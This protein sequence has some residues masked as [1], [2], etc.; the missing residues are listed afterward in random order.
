M[1]QSSTS[2]IRDDPRV[3]SRLVPEASA[4]PQ[5]NSD[6]GKMI[7]VRQRLR[8]WPTSKALRREPLLGPLEKPAMRLRLFAVLATTCGRPAAILIIRD[9]LPAFSVSAES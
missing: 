7:L 2:W 8:Q 3:N 1:R 4:A 9:K 5:K 6:F